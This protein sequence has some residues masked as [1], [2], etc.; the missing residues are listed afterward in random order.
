MSGLT[1][2]AHTFNGEDPIIVL[3]FLRRFMVQS[4]TLGINETQAY[5]AVPY[6]LRGFALEQYEAVRDAHAAT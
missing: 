4:A 2:R 6:F 3:D 5:I 1:V